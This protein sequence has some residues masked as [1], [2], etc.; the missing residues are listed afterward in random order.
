MPNSK[1]DFSHMNDQRRILHS[2]KHIWKGL[3]GVGI[4]RRSSDGFLSSQ[5]CINNGHKGR[6]IGVRCGRY[7]G[8]TEGSSKTDSTRFLLQSEK[9]G[10]AGL[11]AI[12]N[13][14]FAPGGNNLRHDD[15]RDDAHFQQ[16]RG[17]ASGKDQ[18][19]AQDSSARARR[20]SGEIDC[21]PD[22]LTADAVSI[23]RDNPVPV[24]ALTRVVEDVFDEDARA[25]KGQVPSADLRI[26]NHVV[27]ELLASP[28]SHDASTDSL[29]ISMS[30]PSGDRTKQRFR[31][32]Q[33]R[34]MFAQ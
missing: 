6:L 4:N 7:T 34:S 23:G 31:S 5:E 32:L 1:L 16:S 9:N 20:R 33:T 17:R 3:Q 12:S 11:G 27:P 19:T 24:F 2:V 8:Q 13:R 10:T 26:G 22:C 28:S 15:H 30:L 21:F 14:K 25:L 18:A 29:K